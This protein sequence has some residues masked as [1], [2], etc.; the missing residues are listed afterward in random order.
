MNQT[1]FEIARCMLFQAGL[2]RK[3]WAE[4]VNMTCYLINRGPHTG[5][6]CKTPYGVWSD[7][8]ADYSML[9]VFGSTVYYHASEGKLKPRAKKGV[10]VGYGDGVKGRGVETGTRGYPHPISTKISVPIPVPH[11][12][13][14]NPIP[15][16]GIPHP[17]LRVPDLTRI[18]L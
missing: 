9:R 16:S 4:A 14:Y 15:E 6:H 10:C 12:V 13:G 5:I 7:S 1:L 8:R 18:F 2:T 3:F 11:C 17:T